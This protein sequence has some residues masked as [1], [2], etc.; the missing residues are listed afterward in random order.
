MT[1]TD[2]V[3]PGASARPVVRSSLS[4]RN[5]GMCEDA[6]ISDELLWKRAAHLKAPSPD[7]RRSERE[8]H[9]NFQALYRIKHPL[10]PI[11]K[12]GG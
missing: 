2:N 8:F 12:L 1:T 10:E 9:V 11:A 7:K 6:L 5:S 4:A 3:K